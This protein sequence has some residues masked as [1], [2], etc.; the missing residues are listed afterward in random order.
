MIHGY[1]I[2]RTPHWRIWQVYTVDGLRMGFHTTRKLTPLEALRYA[3]KSTPGAT[4]R[5]V[6]RGA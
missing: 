1:P 6:G 2:P 4:I 5:C 3:Q